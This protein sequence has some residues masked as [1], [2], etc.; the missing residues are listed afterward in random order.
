[1]TQGERE[2]QYVWRPNTNDSTTRLRYD[3]EVE[4]FYR[5]FKSSELKHKTPSFSGSLGVI[6]MILQLAFTLL[7]LIGLALFRFLKW[8]AS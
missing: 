5:S 6:G 3:L 7:F 8:V 2:N 1:M 4:H